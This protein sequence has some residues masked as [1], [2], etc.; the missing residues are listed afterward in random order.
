M[1]AVMRRRS[2][3]KGDETAKP[4][5]ICKNRRVL[6]ARTVEF[7]KNRRVLA[8]RTVEFLLRELSSS[9]RTVEFCENRGVLRDRSS[10]VTTEK[11][12]VGCA[13]K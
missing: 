13:A 9:T 1:P 7:Y 4:V 10:L 12:V 8:A 6:A 3:Q 11:S 2:G 5:D